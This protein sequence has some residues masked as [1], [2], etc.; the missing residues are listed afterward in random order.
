MLPGP[1][2]QICFALLAFLSP[3]LCAAPDDTA[4]LPGGKPFIGLLLPLN[5][6]E[7]APAAE[8]VRL[9][10]RASLAELSSMT[11]KQLID[12]RYDKFRKMGSFFT[13]TAVV[14]R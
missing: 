12:D 14:G 9:T 5:A 13:E 11:P 1:R 7:F 8:A 4:S 10:L 2:A 6:A 3:A